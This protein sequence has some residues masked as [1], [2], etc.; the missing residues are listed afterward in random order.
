VSEKPDQKEPDP[1]S[2]DSE[3]TQAPKEVDRDSGEPWAKLSSGDKEE[4]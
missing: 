2:E 1:T 4:L 3:E